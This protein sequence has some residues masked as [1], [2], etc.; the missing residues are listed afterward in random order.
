MPRGAVGVTSGGLIRKQRRDRRVRRL[1]KQRQ[2][3]L[4]IDERSVAAQVR[5]Q[6]HGGTMSLEMVFHAGGALPAR[7]V[8]T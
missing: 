1:E 3:L 2:G 7:G 6:T 8:S 4:P 5:C